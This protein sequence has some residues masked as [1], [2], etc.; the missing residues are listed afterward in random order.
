MFEPE[1]DVRGGGPFSDAHSDTR[2]SCSGISATG[3][4]LDSRGARAL[5][6]TS[7]SGMRG[8]PIPLHGPVARNREARRCGSD[9]GQRAIR[10]AAVLP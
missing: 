7:G 2:P 8:Q 6:A 1:R 3:P 4:E 9:L 10:N 5:A